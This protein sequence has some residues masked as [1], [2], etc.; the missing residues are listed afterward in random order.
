MKNF[1]AM[2]AV[3]S[4]AAVMTTSGAAIAGPIPPQV[5]PPI[6]SLGDEHTQLFLLDQNAIGNDEVTATLTWNPSDFQLGEG[7]STNLV[8]HGNEI[9]NLAV[10]ASNQF[11]S[12]ETIQGLPLGQ[13][14]PETTTLGAL[15]QVATANEDT[16]ATTTLPNMNGSYANVIS[17]T[18]I[19]ALNTIT[20]QGNQ[21]VE[22]PY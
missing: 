5:H 12:D 15:K 14:A 7:L 18:A 13:H 6:P 22:M 8:G 4:V 17:N 1:R 16:F 3:A 20:L 19:G 21:L 11:L 2:I 9:R 10:N